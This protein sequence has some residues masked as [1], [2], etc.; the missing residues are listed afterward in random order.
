MGALIPRGGPAGAVALLP[1]LLAVL[2]AL[3]APARAQTPTGERGPAA[4]SEPAQ[5]EPTENE[6]EGGSDATPAGPEA[7]TPPPGSAAAVAAEHLADGR[8]L[9]RELDFPGCV[10]AMQRALAVPGVGPAQRLEAYE[11]LGAANVVLDREAEAEAAFLAMFELDPYHRVR[12]PSGSPKIE[13]FVEALRARTV[14]D[15]AL[16]GELRLEATLP[17]AARM[18]RPIPVRVDVEGGEVA[19]VRVHLRG[20]EETEWRSVALPGGP[21]R[22]EGEL[23]GLDTTGRLEVYA[24]ARD[25]ARRGGARAGEPLVPLVVEIRE[26]VEDPTPLRRKW[27][28]WTAVGVVAAGV[29]LGV[30]VAVAGRETAPAGTLQP[31]R[32]ELP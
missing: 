23:P 16:D 11:Y 2:L 4:Q 13:R 32:V 9:Y 12:E 17:R 19:S 14:A 24:Q 1:S 7:P 26:R 6:A 27:W 5:S 18:D 22:F 3:P 10:D 31:G 21:R 28:L 15:A 29:A 25:A 20:D 8:R 30:G